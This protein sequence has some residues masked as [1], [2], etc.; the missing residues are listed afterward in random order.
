MTPPCIAIQVRLAVLVLLGLVLA[1]CNATPDKRVLQYLNTDGFGNR[2]TGNAEEENWVAIGDRIGIQDSFQADLRI[3][4]TPVDIDGT[5][6]LPE[7]GAVVVAGLTRTQIEALLTEKYS[8]YFDQLDIKVRIFTRGKK[9]YIFG[10][11]EAPG[12]KDFPGD[13]TLFQA[14]MQAAPKKDSG[15]FGRVR[16]IRADP[17][18]AFIQYFDVTE[19]FTRGDSTFNVHVQ[20]ND[21]IYVPPTMLA[22]FG[23]FLDSLLFPVKFILESLSSAIFSYNALR[24]GYYGGYG[25]NNRGGIF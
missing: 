12:E 16:L 13:L 19:M 25:G 24:G 21:I 8:Q 11:V 9:Y 18:D 7:L 6:I 17:R 15:N 10:E 3:E 4:E 14:L 2:Y 20:E 5:V 1:G 23:Y 22:E